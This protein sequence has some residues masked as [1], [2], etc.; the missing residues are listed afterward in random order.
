MPD[1]QIG[2]LGAGP[3]A[4]GPHRLGVGVAGPQHAQE[5]LEPHVIANDR[6]DDI[7]GR[8]S[9]SRGRRPGRNSPV[10]FRAAGAARGRGALPPR[11]KRSYAACGPAI[12]ATITLCRTTC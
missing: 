1:E 3:Q 10:I 11:A 12:A 8:H 4:T 7:H 6:L 9:G 5:G 2:Q